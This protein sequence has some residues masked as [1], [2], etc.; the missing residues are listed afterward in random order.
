M[1]LHKQNDEVLIKF[2][3]DP[4][5]GL[6]REEFL[7][8]LRNCLDSDISLNVE[9]CWVFG[10]FAENSMHKFSDIDIMI[11]CDT[12]RPFIERARDFYALLKIGPKLDILVYT[13]DEF[14]EL[15]EN[16]SAGFW[17]TA[18]RQMVRVL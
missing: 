17:R 2:D 18:V 14:R 11:I 6:G 13:P 7:T 15:T 16:P 5:H 1:I 3:H 10:S 9:E 12:Q 8:A 4:M